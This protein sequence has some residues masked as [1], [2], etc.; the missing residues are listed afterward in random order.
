MKL[1][2]Q[3]IVGVPLSSVF[4]AAGVTRALMSAGRVCDQ[5]MICTFDKEKAIVVTPNGREVCGF[6]RRGGLYVA[7]LTLTHLRV[8]G[9]GCSVNGDPCSKRSCKPL[10]PPERG[11]G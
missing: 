8:L 5:G 2:M 3:S 10:R 4:Q 7:Q 6:E 9:V 1:N 11:G